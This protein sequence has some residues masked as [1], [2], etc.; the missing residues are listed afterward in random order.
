M[1]REVFKEVSPRERVI[2]RFEHDLG[3]ALLV[4]EVESELEV[5]PPAGICADHLKVSAVPGITL[6]SR[7]HMRRHA[8][9]TLS[10]ERR[11]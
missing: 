9:R 5:V 7:M 3:T 6:T 11:Q 4:D 2:W 1:G 8:A 10:T